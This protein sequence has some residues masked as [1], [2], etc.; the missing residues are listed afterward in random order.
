MMYD[1]YTPAGR[2]VFYPAAF[3]AQCQKFQP[4]IESIM[5]P[6]PISED[7]NYKGSGK[8]KDKAAIITGG[9]SGIGKAVAIAFAKEGA[10]VVIAYLCAYERGD[11]LE[12][13]KLVEKTGRRCFLLEGDVGDEAFCREIVRK[14][15]EVFGR[16]DIVVN[17]AAIQ[18]YE[19]SI[20]DIS[21]PQLERVFRTNIFS[22]FYL[23]K[24]A[25]PFMKR[26]SSIIN[27]TSV[28]AYA[29]YKNLL[30]YSSTKGAMVSLT[31]SLALNLA[32]KGIRVNAVAP[33]PTWTPLIP[34]S[35][36]PY[37]VASIGSDVP[38]GRELQPVEIAPSFVFLA[39][40][41]D[42]AQMTGQV[43]HVNGGTIVNG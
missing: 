2:Y 11:A 9:D 14:T 8:L 28:T 1:Y 25:L 38:L 12:T 6:K 36:S 40:D 39:S 15:V 33:G 41:A 30:D 7:P 16:V 24:A 19:N 35:I 20:E 10:D 34:A 23:I 21:A 5:V 43:L 32:N 29:G 26:G 13:K 3:P 4:G 31:R 42:S 37:M 27:C 22:C 18:I 17:N